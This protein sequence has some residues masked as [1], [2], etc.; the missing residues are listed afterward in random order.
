MAKPLGGGVRVDIHQLHADPVRQK[1]GGNNF[2][3]F[4][5]STVN[6]D[7][8]GSEALWGFTHQPRLV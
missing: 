6:K 2:F 8:L 7:D 4:F 3:F 1:D 5:P